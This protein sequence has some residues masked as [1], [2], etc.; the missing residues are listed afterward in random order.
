MS[1]SRRQMLAAGALTGA[2][3]T[4]PASGQTIGNPDN[5]PQGLINT[6]KTPRSAADPGPQNPVLAGQFPGA[7]SPPPTD[8][9]DLPLFWASFNSAPRR[10]QAGGWARQVTQSDFQVSEEIAGVNM[11]LAAGGVREMHW[12]Q[13]AEWG[14]VSYGECRVTVL[15]LEGRAYVADTKEG[16]LWY[17]PAGYPHSL[18]GLGPDGCEFILCFDSGKQSE[19]NTLLVTDWMAHTPVDILAQNFGVPPDTFKNM[20]THDLWI[21]QGELPGSLAADRAG[22]QN[23][24]GPPPDPFTFSLGSGPI[25]KQNPGGTVQ[26]ADSDNFKAAKTIAAAL[27]TLRPGGLREMHWHPNADEWQ[28]YVKGTAQM[29][30]FNTGPKSVTNDFKAGDIGYIPRNLGHYI[31]NTGE[32]DLVFLEVF[33]AN[34][35][36]D[37]S[38]ADWLSHTPPAMVEAHF[39]IPTRQIAEFPKT[40]AAVRPPFAG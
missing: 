17:F 12:H 21:Y 29:G 33:R 31:K 23:P 30:V 4:A 10:I 2:A 15:D 28:Y 20:F 39:N 8:V 3:L 37:V 38:L 34:R 13:A 6:A 24:K 19:Y 27:V 5:P 40:N 36:E 11:R 14:F 22:V 16:D 18:Q 35:Y 25:A 32:T 1:F 9:G 26:I 7:Y